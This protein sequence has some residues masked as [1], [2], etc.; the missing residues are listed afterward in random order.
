M[1]R[2]IGDTQNCIICGKKAKTW[3]GHVHKK[4]KRVLAGFCKEHDNRESENLLQRKPHPGCA[5]CFGEWEERD[6]LLKEGK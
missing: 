5:G 1:S 2:I 3:T 6:G 4:D